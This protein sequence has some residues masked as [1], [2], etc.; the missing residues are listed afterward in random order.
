MVIPL[1]IDATPS[2]IFSEVPLVV[3]L[4]TFYTALLILTIKQLLSSINA[5]LKRF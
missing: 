1:K 2:M 5:F 3:G 4:E